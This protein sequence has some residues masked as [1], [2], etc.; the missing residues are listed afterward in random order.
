MLLPFLIPSSILLGRPAPHRSLRRGL[1]VVSSLWVIG[2]VEGVEA[3]W[4]LRVVPALHHEGVR[5]AADHVDLW[6]RGGG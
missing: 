1:V 6:G 3:R 5:L 2:D 4:P